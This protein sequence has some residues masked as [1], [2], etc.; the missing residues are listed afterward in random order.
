MDIKVRLLNISELLGLART[1]YKAR[2]KYILFLCA[3]AILPMTIAE[4][5]ITIPVDVLADPTKFAIND[6]L[7]VLSRYV[8]L[9][10]LLNVV[11]TP[12]YYSGM[13]YIAMQNPSASSPEQ[14][15]PLHSILDV[16]INKWAKLFVSGLLYAAI[17]LITSPIFFL[18]FFFLVAFYFAT[19]YGAIG[20]IWGINA[21][22]A[23]Y[24]LVRGRWFKTFGFVLL[25][26]TSMYAVSLLIQTLIGLFIPTTPINAF[27]NTI[28]S[29]MI[30]MVVRILCSFF[31]LVM[32]LKFLNIYYTKGAHNVN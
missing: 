7:R 22:K 19:F 17:S 10:L 2:F 15:I 31:D 30:I 11:F 8:G 13:T 23:S 9:T 4:S 6:I 3:I 21:L 29:F 1:C 20:D 28:I 27:A 18:M 12:I 26:N 5:L 25:V 16:T 24:N 14:P 32:S